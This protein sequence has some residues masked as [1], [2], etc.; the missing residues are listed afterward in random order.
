[1]SITSGPLITLTIVM[2]ILFSHA[3]V[4][5]AIATLA[6]EPW[7][8]KFLLPLEKSMALRQEKGSAK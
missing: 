3:A 7:E 1:M 5:P 8:M 2:M 6:F 4:S